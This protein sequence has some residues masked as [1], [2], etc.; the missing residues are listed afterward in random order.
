M[1]N[2]R[3][4]LS[5]AIPSLA[6]MAAAATPALAQQN[7]QYIT[8]DPGFTSETAGKKEVLEFFS[9]ACSHCAVMAPM[10]EELAKTLP[11]SFTLVN[12]PVQFNASMVPM[13]HLYYSL[14]ALDRKDLHL[15]VFDAIHKEK[16]R[17]FTRDDIVDWAAKQ[18]IDKQEFSATYDSFGVAAKVKRAAELG[19]QYK[20]NST[21]SY[22]VAGKY[23]TSPGMTGTYESAITL[24]KELVAK[25]AAQ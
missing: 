11:D 2:L 17:L 15:K 22:A 3:K 19:N 25:E 7:P 5:R 23:V 4:F 1:M 21:P 9:Y 24:I 16:Q 8:L 12:V 18:G 13:Q 20:I 10:S 6:L 14:V